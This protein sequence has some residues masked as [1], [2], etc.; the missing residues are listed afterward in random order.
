MPEHV[1]RDVTGEVYT[2]E[3]WV[4]EYL[5]DADYLIDEKT[6][7][8]TETNSSLNSSTEGS[9]LN[10]VTLACTESFV[11][12]DGLQSVVSSQG[13]FASEQWPELRP[14]LPPTGSGNCDQSE[15]RNSWE[16]LCTKTVAGVNL[17]NVNSDSDTASES[18][19]CST[20]ENDY[21]INAPASSAPLESTTRS[22]I[23]QFRM[24]VEKEAK[25]ARSERA[26]QLDENKKT[27][28]TGK[29]LAKSKPRVK[30]VIT[31]QDDGR[32]A[33]ANQNL[34]AP[35]KSSEASV[36][37]FCE[38]GHK[39][40][41]FE[42]SAHKWIKDHTATSKMLRMHNSSGNNCHVHKEFNHSFMCR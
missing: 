21:E 41:I 42:S 40:V 28:D 32:S 35:P 25:H 36:N 5:N 9:T 3:K 20:E 18:S 6:D 39:H 13:S 19:S 33:N 2:T 30:K 23:E 37:I 8:S 31:P 29:L 16:S 12:C 38:A 26:R 1:E 11:I 7:H 22:E 17:D 34:P 4:S 24:T 10:L 14:S 15:T 27:Q